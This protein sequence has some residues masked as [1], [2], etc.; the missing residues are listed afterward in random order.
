M[1]LRLNRRQHRAWW[2]NGWT[3]AELRV[4]VTSRMWRESREARQAGRRGTDRAKWEES[5]GVIGGKTGEKK[6]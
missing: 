2:F 5:D 4:E 3:M 1:G 6:A